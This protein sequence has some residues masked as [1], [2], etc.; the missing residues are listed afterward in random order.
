[1][2]RLSTIAATVAVAAGLELL[3]SHDGF[4]IQPPAKAGAPTYTYSE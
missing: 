1:M 4:V 2:L 3:G